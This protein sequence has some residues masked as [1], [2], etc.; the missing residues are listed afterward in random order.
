ML[1]ISTIIINNNSKIHNK[2]PNNNSNKHFIVMVY[3]NLNNNNKILC[4]IYKII[5]LWMIKTILL[6]KKMKHLKNF[7]VVTNNAIKILR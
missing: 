1:I 7:S 3:N 4:K 2:L 6:I 5:K